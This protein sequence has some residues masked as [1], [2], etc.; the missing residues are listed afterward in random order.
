MTPGK[1]EK[2]VALSHPEGIQELFVIQNE[3][4]DFFGALARERGGRAVVNGR[5]RFPD[6]TQWYFHSLP[7]D[8]LDLRNRLVS[9]C[10]AITALYDTDLFYLK[11]RSVIGYD[12]FVRRLRAAELGAARA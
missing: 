1:G 9:V 11:F 3:R 12:E 8:P 4:I 5:V 7:G 10:E 2:T 6:G